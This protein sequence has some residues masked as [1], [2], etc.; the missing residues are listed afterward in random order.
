MAIDALEYDETHEDANPA[1]ALEVRLNSC[2]YMW[3][4]PVFD[5]LVF[6]YNWY[7]D[8]NYRINRCDYWVGG[9]V[10]CEDSPF[11]SFE[12]LEKLTEPPPLY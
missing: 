4:M 1:A 6:H 2:S 3:P 5:A 10:L 8:K 9:W 7:W 12:Q 11:L